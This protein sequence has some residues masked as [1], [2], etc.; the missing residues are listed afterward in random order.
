MDQKVAPNLTLRE[1]TI[2]HNRFDK[3]SFDVTIC[4]QSER[5]LEPT[6]KKTKIF[7]F[8]Q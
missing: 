8:F 6:L 3:I 4:F 5:L 7:Y 1:L 2:K